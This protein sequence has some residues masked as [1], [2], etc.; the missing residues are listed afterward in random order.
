M[1]TRPAHLCRLL[2]L[3]CLCLIPRQLRGR[4]AALV[5]ALIAGALAALPTAAPAQRVVV[6]QE[7]TIADGDRYEVFA[8]AGEQVVV[9]RDRGSAV[10]LA[11]YNDRMEQAW[12]RELT[13]D[14]GRPSPIGALVSRGEVVVFYTYR[15]DRGLYLKMHRYSDAGNLTDSL[16]V[17]EL[18]DEFLSPDFS[19]HADPAGQYAVFTRQIDGTTWVLLGV[20]VATGRVLCRERVAF[21]FGSGPADS[22][23]HGPYVDARGSTYFWA[24]RNNRRSR[25]D[26]HDLLVARVAITGE[27]ATARVSLPE[28]LVF[29]L[30]LAV[31]E[32]NARVVLGGYYADD[33]DMAAGVML[34]RLDYA[35]AGEPEV[36]LSPFPASVV[37]SV[38]PKDRRATGV[39]NLDALDLVFRAD[40]GVL[41]IGEQRRMTLRTVGGRGG[42]FGATMKT[43]YLYEDIVL[44]VVG[45]PPTS[46][47]PGDWHEVL[48]KKQFSQD[49]GAAFSGYFIAWT[50]RQLRLIYNDEVRSGGT[51]SEYTLDG[52]G[53]IERHSIMN[54]EYQ[55]LWLR[56]EAAVQV[57][58]TDL[59]IPSERRNRLRLVRLSYG[60]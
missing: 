39:E 21:E 42:Y 10:E 7:I 50:P 32:A 17:T 51:V 29:D 27:A 59:V 55:D 25:L 54:T 48:P 47:A 33:P 24:Q 18:T 26:E 5:A 60:A 6:S 30:E 12:S 46:Q 58:G 23:I 31:D 3:A 57:S 8:G 13:L 38:D 15:R 45:A 22:G 52:T 14:K 11:A 43:D 28:T 1:P 4:S 35:L 56:H 44:S 37:T 49:D 34:I 9:Y 16:T 2:A 40:G 36:A 53:G 41:V 19:L 20:E